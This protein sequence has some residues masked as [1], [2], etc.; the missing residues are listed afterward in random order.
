VPS[1]LPRASERRLAFRDARAATLLGGRCV[2][3]LQDGR[4][5]RHRADGMRNASAAPRRASPSPAARGR[6]PAGS[7][8]A[9]RGAN[10][11]EALAVGARGEL[12]S[13]WGRRESRGLNRIRYRAMT[14]HS[15]NVDA[16][17][18]GN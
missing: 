17:E 2:G 15:V 9:R 16:V 1:L 6:V 11:T 8:A 13:H 3:T 14:G 10:R 7:G 4:A 12:S 5:G 18:N